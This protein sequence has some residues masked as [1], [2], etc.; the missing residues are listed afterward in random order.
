MLRAAIVATVTRCTRHAWAVIAVMAALGVASG[1]YATRHFAINTDINKLISSN[2]DWR[3]RDQQF[4]K[5]FDRDHTILAVVEAPTPELTSTATA[6]SSAPFPGSRPRG[7]DCSTWA[8]WSS[9]P[10]T[11]ARAMAINY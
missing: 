1:V 7:V 2:L 10:K 5:A 3:Q 8:I 11:S 4:E 9:S 6:A